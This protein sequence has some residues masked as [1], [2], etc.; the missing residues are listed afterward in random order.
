MNRLLFVLL[1]LGTLTVLSLGWTGDATACPGCKEALANESEE[2][3]GE[4]Y[5]NLAWNPAHAY[6]YSVLFM[7]AV[8]AT[9]LITFG[10]AC[11]VMTRKPSA[12]PEKLDWEVDERA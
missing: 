5:Q 12:P 9:I 1:L 3:L 11:W 2:E 6:S 4:E 8:P 10:T 7:L